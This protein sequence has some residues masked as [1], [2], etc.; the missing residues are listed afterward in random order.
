M[1][2]EIVFGLSNT[3]VSNRVLKNREKALYKKLVKNKIYY[4]SI[5]FILQLQSLLMFINLK[6]ANYQCLHFELLG[7]CQTYGARMPDIAH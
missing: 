3:G 5:A 1:H 2:R 6:P 4:I 7:C